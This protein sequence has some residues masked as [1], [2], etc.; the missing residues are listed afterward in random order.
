MGLD[1]ENSMFQIMDSLRKNLWSV[2]WSTQKG[3]YCNEPIT[4]N[5]KYC[6]H[7]NGICKENANLQNLLKEAQKQ[8]IN[9]A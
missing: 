2:Y 1:M 8:S 7:Y 6:R 3:K 5:C 4:S 9:A